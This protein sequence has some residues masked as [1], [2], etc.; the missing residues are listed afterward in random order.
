MITL[1]TPPPRGLPLPLSFHRSQFSTQTLLAISRLVMAGFGDLSGSCRRRRRGIS[2]CGERIMLQSDHTDKYLLINKLAPHV[3]SI[4]NERGEI[5]LRIFTRSTSYNDPALV[6]AC[7][8]LFGDRGVFS[9]GRMLPQFAWL[10][11]PTRDGPGLA[12]LVPSLQRAA[13]GGAFQFEGTIHYIASELSPEYTKAITA[14]N[15]L[16]TLGFDI[17]N[18]SEMRAGIPN[19]DTAVIQLCGS[20]ADC[21]VFHVH[22][23]DCVRKSAA[24]RSTDRGNLILPLDLVDLLASKEL[25]GVN[26][27]GDITNLKKAFPACTRLKK[28]V[29]VNDLLKDHRLLK[30]I[31]GPRTGRGVQAL[32]RLLLH[33]DLDKEVGGGACVNWE[34]TPLPECNQQYA[35]ND[36]WAHDMLWL[37]I[38]HPEQLSAQHVPACNAAPTGHEPPASLD[39]EEEP[40]RETRASSARSAGLENT[41]SVT[42]G[43]RAMAEATPVVVSSDEFQIDL[44]DEDVHQPADEDIPVENE[45]ESKACLTALSQQI[46]GAAKKCV[47]RYAAKPHKKKARIPLDLPDEQREEL[48]PSPSPRASNR[49]PRMASCTS[50]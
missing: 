46:L 4:M 22:N 8:S 3:F 44:V 37:R 23:F 45:E 35:A 33:Q 20:A 48:Q 18:W 32:V 27:K 15:K 24:A 25:T 30:M 39:I 38:M 7:E 41:R 47:D 29:E 16:D 11:C 19:H 1:K 28:L 43:M 6:M 36:A 40:R 2:S 10:D 50:R 21:Y 42:P 5:L 49:G 12:K 26:I 34:T 14:L 17:E 31:A 13:L 9:D